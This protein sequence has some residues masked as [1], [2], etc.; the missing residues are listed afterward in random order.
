MKPVIYE[1]QRSL[2]ARFSI[3]L[4]VVII[5]LTALISYEGGAL[6]T[7]RSGAGGNISE[8]T[9]YYADG[10]NLTVLSYFYDQNGNPAKGIIAN[11]TLNSTTY[12]GIEI[13]PGTFEFHFI[14]NS[15]SSI[16]SLNYSYRTFGFRTNTVDSVAINLAQLN[17]SGMDVV[18]GLVQSGNSSNLGFMLFYVG[19]IGNHTSPPVNVYVGTVGAVP[20]NT[21]S[22]IK[23]NSWAA[24]YSGFTHVSVFPD[25][26]ASAIGNT[27]GVLVMSNIS[28]NSIPYGMLAYSFHPIGPLSIYKPYTASTIES[29]FFSAEGSLLSIFIPLLAVFMAY[30][31]YGKDRVTGVLESI[32]KRPLTKGEAIRSRFLANSVVIAASIVV[33][34]VI[35]DLISSRYFHVFMPLSF[36]LFISW[37]YSIVGIAFLALSYL[38]SHVFKS[39]GALLGVLIAIFMMFSLFWSVIFDVITAAFSI[40]S[41]TSTYITSQVIFNYASPTGYT[42]LIQLFFTHTMGGG[43]GG[44]FGASQNINPATYGVT[45]IFLFIAG[46]LWVA[47]PFAIAH[48]LAV[49]R[50]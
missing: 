48:Q 8:V 11:G 49:K 39:Q 20:P 37:A 30:F 47:I 33:A 5:G 12:S 13:S 17:Y 2:T 3:I 22:F 32:L 27:Y 18:P 7:A 43:F 34:V 15:K 19:N 40:P 41:V 44:G 29:A 4:I 36:L 16:M 14:T 9:G 24:Q 10:M 26:G 46:I 6:S 1:I 25:L 21:T 38:F 50:D 45:L 31:T 23:N 35:S 28:S 42:S